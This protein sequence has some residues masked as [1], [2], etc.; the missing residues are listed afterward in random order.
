MLKKLVYKELQSTALYFTLF[1]IF[2]KKKRAAVLNCV[3]LVFQYKRNQ[4]CQC[5]FILRATK[6]NPSVL[7]VS[8]EREPA[9]K[10]PRTVNLSFFIVMMLNLII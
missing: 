9:V 4:D 3:L 1:L 5:V 2:L 7:T 10:K 8:S 6:A